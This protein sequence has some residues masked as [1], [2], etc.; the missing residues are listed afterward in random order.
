MDLKTLVFESI[1]EGRKNAITAKD[2]ALK[3]GLPSANSQVTVRSFI[4]ELIIE[5]GALIA[6]STKKP[7][8]FFKIASEDELTE[9]IAS[10]ENRIKEI[11]NRKNCLKNT[12]QCTGKYPKK[13]EN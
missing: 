2:I 4:T 12:Y 13:F 3:V 10:L 11:E 8:G 7:A 6:S 9:Y 5:D 1:P